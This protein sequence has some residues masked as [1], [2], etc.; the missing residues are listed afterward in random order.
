MFAIEID[1][2]DFVALP[3][4]ANLTVLVSGPPEPH[5][6]LIERLMRKAGL[7]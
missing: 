3:V 4:T 1:T 7:E 6:V 5:L 2:S